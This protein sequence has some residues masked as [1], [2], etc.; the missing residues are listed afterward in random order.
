M[1]IDQDLQSFVQN[2]L[3]KEDSA[4]AIVMDAHTG[5]VYAMASYPAF[6]PNLF[7]RGMPQTTWEKLLNTRGH[8]MTNKA[9]SGLYPPASTFK[10]ITGLA[11]LEAGVINEHTR[12]NCSGHYDLNNQRFHCWKKRGHG[13]VNL[14]DALEQS[15]DVYFYEI[16]NKIGIDKIARM[17]RKLGLEDNFDHILKESRPGLVP[18][19]NWKMGNNGQVWRPGDTI[20]TSIGQGSL[21]AS[22]LH[23]AQMTARLING[24][25][26]ISP[27]II[28][29]DQNLTP[30][31]KSLNISE[32]HLRL[33]KKAWIALL[34]DRTAQRADHA[35][36]TKNSPWAARPEPPKLDALPALSVMRASKTKS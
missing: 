27:R 21:L 35:S 34:T 5:E 15:C 22:P 13:S 12:F 25:N 3:S 1:T 11:G 18:D 4:S 33:I 32:A 20:V 36:T 29:P 26:A 17:A 14:K 2:R 31:P 10:M 9:V 23:L 28:L 7:V 16:A 24:G 30:A 19:R 6:D 8:P